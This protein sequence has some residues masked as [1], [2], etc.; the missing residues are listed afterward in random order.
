MQLCLLLRQREGRSESHE[1][2]WDQH[3][4]LQ[5]AERGQQQ[6][7]GRLHRRLHRLIREEQEAAQ[8]HHLQHVSAGGA[9][10][11]FSEDTLS[12]RVRPRAAGSEDGAHRGSG[13]GAFQGSC[14]TVYTFLKL[15]CSF[16]KKKTEFMICFEACFIFLQFQKSC[17][18]V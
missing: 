17:D 8:P 13:S 4:L 3:R 14:I 2:R 6:L 5:Q 16:Q 12:R 11:S 18:V 1:L 15:L 7:A 9:G 10:E